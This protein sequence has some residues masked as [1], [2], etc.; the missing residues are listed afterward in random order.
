MSRLHWPAIVDQAAGIVSEYNTPVTLRQLFYRLVAARVLPNTDTSYKTLSARAAEARRDGRFP[1][2]ADRGR[3]I[4]QPWSFTGPE[5]ALRYVVERYRRDR[6][7]GQP[8]SVYLGVEKDGLVSQLS[9]WF[10]DLGVP[11]VALKG[12]A[13]QSLV[14]SVKS[15]VADQRRPAVLLYAGDFDP[16]GEDIDRD[17]AERTGCFDKVIRVALDADQVESFDLPPAP[18]KA[19]DARA[20][21]FTARHGRLVQVELDALDPTD[22]RDLYQTAVDQFWDVSA[23]EAVRAEEAEDL[24]ALEAML[25]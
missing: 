15:H 17:F 1:E 8:W 25:R 21:R 4:T 24:E 22:L 9:A 13:S 10:G 16:T 14:E 12:Y 11:I 20:A 5:N 2:L 23:Y 3:T 19:T 7:E 18:G 6:T